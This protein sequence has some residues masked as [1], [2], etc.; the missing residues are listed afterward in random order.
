MQD[1]KWSQERTL[2]DALRHSDAYYVIACFTSLSTID[3]T[4]HL[5]TSLAMPSNKRRKFHDDKAVEAKV[6]TLPMKTS[7]EDNQIIQLCVYKHLNW[8]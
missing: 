5:L 8:W 6:A 7:F 3:K 4:F 1:S 2:F